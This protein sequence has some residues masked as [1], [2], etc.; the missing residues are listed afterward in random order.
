VADAAPRAQAD[1]AS[2][3][4]TAAETRDAAA[5]ATKEARIA[6]AAASAA[7]QER[8]ARVDELCA[9][10]AVSALAAKLSG[11]LQDVVRKS[12]AD[13]DLTARAAGTLLALGSEAPI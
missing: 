10:A 3:E 7:E 1:A 6:A 2:A 12:R 4:Q 13:C 11:C 5:Q 9:H 8:I